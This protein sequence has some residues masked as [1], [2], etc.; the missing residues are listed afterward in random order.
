MPGIFRPS[1]FSRPWHAA[2][3]TT[4]VIVRHTSALLPVEP[5]AVLP[6]APGALP[7]W[8]S[9]RGSRYVGRPYNSHRQAWRSSHFGCDVDRASAVLSVFFLLG[10][11]S[12]TYSVL[13]PSLWIWVRLAHMQRSWIPLV[14]PLRRLRCLTPSRSFQLRRP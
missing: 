7:F 2:A 9:P 6:E 5:S 4:A 12:Q 8:V 14:L 1:T 3:A 11:R 13:A 10:R